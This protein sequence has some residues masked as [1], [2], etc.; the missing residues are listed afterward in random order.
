VEAPS[1]FPTVYLEQEARALLTRLERLKPFSLVMP[2]TVSAAVPP[3]AL[4]AIEGLL[5]KARRE[6]R[7]SIQRFLGWLKSEQGRRA[8][9]AEAQRKFTFLRLRFNAII[10]QCDI[11]GDVL[12]QRSEHEAGVWVAGLDDLAA[13]A[14]KL[15]TCH[16][17]GPPVICY[18]DH[19]HGA[20][21]RRTRTRL[22]GGELNPVAVIRLPRERM[23]G[24]GI[25]SSVVHEVGHEGAARLDLV[26]SLRRALEQQPHSSESAATAFRY[27]H[28]CLSEIVADLWS[29]ARVGAAS[30]LG[31]IGVVSLPRPF[32][33]RIDLQDPHPAPYLRVKLS[34]AMGRELY[35]HPQWDAIE[36]LWE[37]LYPLEGLQPALRSSVEVIQDSIGEF[38]LLL[39]DHRPQ[40]VNGRSLR[41]V[42]TIA[43]CQP[44]SLAQ[45]F[46]EW[47]RHPELLADVPPCLAFATIGQAR[48][49]GRITPELESEN[50]SKLLTWWALQGALTSI[51]CRPTLSSS[52]AQ[53][54]AP[55]SIR[56]VHDERIT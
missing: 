24:C 15:P 1:I 9:A 54:L 3:R 26:K 47:Q 39:L 6:L 11:F 33:F 28:R 50:L 36:S 46:T 16:F 35:P 4:S 56:S 30:T 2:M 45:R 25:A 8:T 44:A 40:S 41:E 32:V 18:L 10:S 21:I 22:P 55:R 19:G 53:P 31:L 20:A 37:D 48:L 52:S 12:A 14:L 13:D 49:D 27:W 43:T 29:V 17:E 23:I 5:S 42:F 51:Q 34:I 7:W 38:V